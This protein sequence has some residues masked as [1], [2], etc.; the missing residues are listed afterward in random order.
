MVYPSRFSGQE[1]AMSRNQFYKDSFFKRRPKKTFGDT[2]RSAFRKALLVATA[3]AAADGYHHY[4]TQEDLTAT[5]TSVEQ[6]AGA[7]PRTIVHTDNGTFVNDATWLHFKGDG[8]THSIA[9]ALRPGAHVNLRV[10]GLHPSALGF[11]PDSFG[12][13]RNILAVNVLSGGTYAAAPAAQA[14]KPAPSP[15]PAPVQTPAPIGDGPRTQTGVVADKDLA[16]PQTCADIANLE[17]TRATNPQVYRDLAILERLPLTGRA[18]FAQVTNPDAFLRSCLTPYDENSGT[19][20]EY[21][22]KRLNIMRG[23]SSETAFHELFHAR[24]DLND[25]EQLGAKMTMRDAAISNA[26]QEATAVAYSL[27]AEHE[28]QKHG[29]AVAKNSDTNRVGAA[30]KDGT[31]AVFNKTYKTAFAENAALAADAREAKALE[32]AGRAVVRALMLGDDDDWLRSYAQLVVANLNNNR[33]IYSRNTGNEEGY[34]QTR[35]SVFEKQG[36]VSADINIIPREFLGADAERQINRCFTLM[37]IRVTPANTG[38]D[39]GM[40]RNT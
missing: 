35:D 3:A 32:A 4:G 15:A 37:G 1:Y 30:D 24:Q 14:A 38:A 31:R 40:R 10:Y 28:A 34:A 39:Y 16:L 13:Y 20:G 17:D 22:N 11:S 25:A 21:S 8:S 29:I 19:S 5:V 33:G 27:M 9:N 7:K 2:L 23:V 36:S 6:L 26:L 18:I 12:M